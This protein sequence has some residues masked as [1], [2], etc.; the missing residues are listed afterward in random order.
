MSK[1]KPLKE[2]PAELSPIQVDK[3]KLIRRLKGDK[4]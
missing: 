2:K 3:Q 4:K 1:P